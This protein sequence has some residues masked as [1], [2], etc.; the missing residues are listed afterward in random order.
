[1]L[2]HLHD[3]HRALW[4]PATQLAEV[5]ARMFSARGSWFNQLPGAARLAAGYEL[6][7]RLGKRYDKPAFGISSVDV[8]GARV[9]VIEETVM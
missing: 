8:R 1:V 5:T 7:F 3:Y 6:F 9:G 2:Y 4:G